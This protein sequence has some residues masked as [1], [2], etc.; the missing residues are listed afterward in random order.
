[1][2]VYEVGVSGIELVSRWSISA[3]SAEQELKI[4][5]LSPN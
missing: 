1:M 4:S 2:E 3:E 5:G